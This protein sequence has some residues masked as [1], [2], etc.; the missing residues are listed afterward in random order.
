MND[1]VVRLEGFA[2]SLKGQR[3]WV[4]GPPST[5]GKQILNRLTVLEEE[6]LGRGRKVLLIQNQRDL[7]MRWSQ[8][9]Q[10]D[11]TFRIRETQDLRLSVTYIQNA[12]KPIRV[13]WIGDE[14]PSTLLAAV[15][16]SDI[17]FIVGS[18]TVPRGVWSAIFWHTTTDQPLIEEG[19]GPRMS[20]P[21]VQKLNLPSVL[22]ELKASNV[23]LVWSSIGEK[24]KG[25][26]VYWYDAEEE[27][28]TNEPMEPR[29]MS[30]LL[31]EIADSICPKE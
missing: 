22:R 13:V 30:G 1:A 24:E 28:V 9:T 11:A 27:M 3:L 16:T 19:L 25:G 21:T 7:P 5:I 10:W 31:R 20:G 2:S 14:P 8:K 29:E 23:G 18:T 15:N 4:C 26:S 12:A 17:T 6:L